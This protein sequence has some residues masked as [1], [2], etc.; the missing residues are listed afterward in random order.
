MQNVFRTLTLATVVVFAGTAP[1][2]AQT[3]S[4][5]CFDF[6]MGSWVD[7]DAGL[8]WGYNAVCVDSVLNN[9]WYSCDLFAADYPFHLFANGLDEEANVAARFE[10]WRLPTIEEAD[11]AWVKGL[12]TLDRDPFLDPLN[13]CDP[14]LDRI[15]W[16][17]SGRGKRAFAIRPSTGEVLFFRKVSWGVSLVVRSI[18]PGTGGPGNGNGKG[19]NK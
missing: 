19:K 12:F 15:R 14:R 6:D 10:G 7:E 5:Y 9:S 13:L 11:A 8:V 4:P 1:V 3:P 2:S 18:N 17:S 16:M